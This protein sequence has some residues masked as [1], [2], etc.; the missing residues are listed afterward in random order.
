MT[1]ST[2]KIYD[3]FYFFDRYGREE[4]LSLFDKTIKT[5][6]TLPKYKKLYVERPQCPLALTT[7]TEEELRVWPVRS[8]NS[9]IVGGRGIGRGGVTSPT[10][11][12]GRGTRGGYFPRPDLG[13]RTLFEEESLSRV[14]GVA[15][16]VSFSNLKI[17]RIQIGIFI[18][19]VFSGLDR[20]K[21][22]RNQ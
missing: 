12:R 19:C 10:I 16:R 22:Y 4:F 2:F 5:P 15:G 6:D 7:T 13:S 9:T 20:Q 11:S 3:F 17:I 8:P 14:G 1:S 21:R 18:F